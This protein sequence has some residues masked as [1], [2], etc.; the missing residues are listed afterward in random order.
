V[1]RLINIEYKWLSSE[2]KYFFEGKWKY[3]PKNKTWDID[4]QKAD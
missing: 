4:Y 3:N 2:K 1:Y